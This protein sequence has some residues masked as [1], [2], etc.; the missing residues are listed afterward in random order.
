MR[1]RLLSIHLYLKVRRSCPNIE[2]VIGMD[3]LLRSNLSYTTTFSLS[4]RWS[5]NTGLTVMYVVP[6][7]F[8]LLSI[9]S[10][11]ILKQ[12]L[13][14]SSHLIYRLIMI[15]EII[16]S[17]T[18]STLW[19]TDKNNSVSFESLGTYFH[20]SSYCDISNK[21]CLDLHNCRYSIYIV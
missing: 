20:N 9:I 10:K 6:P 3:P 7:C 19:G 1:S 15:W 11:T 17:V 2:N 5:L 13:K 8:N 12:F 14:P 4:M 21:I 18:S 16:V